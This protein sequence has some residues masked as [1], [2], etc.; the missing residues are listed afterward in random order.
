MGLICSEAESEHAVQS[1]PEDRHADEEPPGF[2]GAHR[3]HTLPVFD[4]VG[5]GLPFQGVIPDPGL[6][7]L[8][9]AVPASLIAS[10]QLD[11]VV[12]PGDEREQRWEHQRHTHDYSVKD[13]YRLHL[14]SFCG[15]SLTLPKTRNIVH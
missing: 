3:S 9:I 5:V 7:R 10:L 14:D 2:K 8:T 12:E 4:V 1:A 13:S 6:S 15:A 11:A